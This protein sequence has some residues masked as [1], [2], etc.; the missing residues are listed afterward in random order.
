MFQLQ[1]LRAD[2]G[3]LQKGT[4]TPPTQQNN[5]FEKDNEFFFMVK[6]FRYLK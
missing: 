4:L 3:N 1:I 6:K 2:L 5:T